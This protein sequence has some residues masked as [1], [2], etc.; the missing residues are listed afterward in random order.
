MFKK[1]CFIRK[2][3]L[4]LLYKLWE[5]GYE[6]CPCCH[7]KESVWL[8]NLTMDDS[9]HGVVYSD[10]TMPLTV[11]GVLEL[12]LSEVTTEIDCGTNEELFLAIAALRDDIDI[13]QWFILQDGSWGKCE[14]E[15]M[16]DMWGD[17]DEE[18]GE[19]YPRKATV[20]ELLEHFKPY[21]NDSTRQS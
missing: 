8:N 17:F 3:N 4:E 21:E 16:V 12:Y 18:I 1:E 7:F 10:E 19:K 2:N 6:I 13:N 9:V 11:E 20:K 5:I 15:S 14:C